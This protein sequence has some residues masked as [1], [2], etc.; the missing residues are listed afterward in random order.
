MKKKKGKKRAPPRRA[1]AAPPAP[2]PAAA[3]PPAAPAPVRLGRPP[4]DPTPDVVEAVCRIVRQAGTY[5]DAAIYVGVGRSTFF[6]WKAKGEQAKRDRRR[7]Q[8]SDFLDALDDARAQRRIALELK[9]QS[10]AQKAPKVLLDY[11]ERVE[12]ERFRPPRV[13]VMIHDELASGLESLAEEFRNEPEILERALRAIAREN[14][15]P[16]P[17]PD[18][19]PA[20]GGDDQD[21][22]PAVHT[23]PA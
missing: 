14:G 19:D 5:E 4:K 13:D 11:A 1:P 17:Q 8:Y 3:A 7:D 21:R 20:G 6:A 18:P 2:P 16:A 23:P 15:A 10:L 9:I 12:R 22:G